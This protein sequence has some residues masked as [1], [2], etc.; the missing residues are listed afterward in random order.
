MQ[1]TR[2]FTVLL[3][4]ATFGKMN[5]VQPPAN[6]QA[7]TPAER[8]GT[9]YTDLLHTIEGRGTDTVNAIFPLHVSNIHIGG[10]TGIKEDME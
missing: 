3:Q 7:R 5:P 8:R 9:H 2:V 6:D 1:A 4:L 10:A